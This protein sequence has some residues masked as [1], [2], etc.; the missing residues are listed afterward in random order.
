[1]T[2]SAAAGG[3][4]Y[5]ADGDVEDQVARFAADGFNLLSAPWS[6][7]APSTMASA[8]NAGLRQGV[9]VLADAGGPLTTDIVEASNKLMHCRKYA[10][11]FDHSALS[12]AHD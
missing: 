12:F 6:A 4:S 10:A 7:E 9:V 5:Q 1:M 2:V 3:S 8:L 11:L